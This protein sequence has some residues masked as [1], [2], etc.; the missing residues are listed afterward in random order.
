MK[1]TLPGGEHARGPGQHRGVQVV[2][3]GV[4]RA[5]DLGREG[6]TG[7]LGHRQRVHVRA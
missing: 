4:H 1:I 3:A 6:K 2:A 5:V 7:R